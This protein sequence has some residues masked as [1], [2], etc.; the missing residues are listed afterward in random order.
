MDCIQEEMTEK[1]YK[2]KEKKKREKL[3]KYKNFEKKILN[4]IIFS[5]YRAC[6]IALK[7]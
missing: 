7:I 1:F 4:I 5:E 2:K 3:K 6:L